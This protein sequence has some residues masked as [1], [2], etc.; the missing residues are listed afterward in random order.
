MGGYFVYFERSDRQSVNGFF[1]SDLTARLQFF[2]RYMGVNGNE[3]KNNTDKAYSQMS[4]L[5]HHSL[6][7]I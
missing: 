1:M 3:G 4:L 2:V 7:T 6:L 5:S